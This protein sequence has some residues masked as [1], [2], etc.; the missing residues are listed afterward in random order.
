[1]KSRIQKK[2]PL[3]STGKMFDL[4]SI[5]LIGQRSTSNIYRAIEITTGKL[6]TLERVEWSLCS[7]VIN[8]V[9][10]MEKLNHPNIIKPSDSY[11]ESETDGQYVII[12]MPYYTDI[13]VR[14]LY[15]HMHEKKLHLVENPIAYILL[16]IAKGL[17]Y[18]HKLKII[19]R[20]IQAANVVIGADGGIKIFGFYYAV[21]LTWRNAECKNFDTAPDSIRWEAP[22]V[23][24]KTP[25][26]RK[27]DVWSLGM[28]GLELAATTVPYAEKESDK[29]VEDAL[30]A[31][32][33]PQTNALE[34]YDKETLQ[35]FVHKT[36]I[37]R[38]KYKR[39]HSTRPDV[40]SLKE[41][42]LLKKLNKNPETKTKMTN[43]FMNFAN[44]NANAKIVNLKEHDEHSGGYW[45][46]VNSRTSITLS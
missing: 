18:M 30:I 25:F 35:D 6:Q 41:H 37:M 31:K 12:V 4:K 26:G 27:A 40:K 45:Y 15:A 43:F 38:V 17:A 42:I 29:E 8:H 13:T 34:R 44:T 16:G 9:E 7:R 39:K 33:C 46:V 24:M 11:L 21:K 2:F 5:Q 22:E 10:I 1:M 23:A 36:M 28:T 20:G 32:E 19:H 3:R 14:D